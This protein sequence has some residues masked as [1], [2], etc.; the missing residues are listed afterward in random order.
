VEDVIMAGTT[1]AHT[2]HTD[3]AAKRIVVGVD[4]SEPS[5]R[6]L[7]WAARQAK[8]FGVP[9]QV[10]ITWELPATYGWAAPLPE[11]LDLEGDSRGVVTD[12]VAEVIGPDA[13]NLDLTL[14]IIE[15]HPAAVLL[16]ESET[17][18]LLVVGSR[19]HGSFAGMLLGSVGHHLVAH[20]H[21]PVVIVRDGKPAPA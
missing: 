1:E 13:A 3:R 18:S 2:E 5:K 11:G 9:L 15:G 14:S 4:G 8:E 12:E 16:R 6:A 17:A 19:G 20:S 21:C 10:V 7:A